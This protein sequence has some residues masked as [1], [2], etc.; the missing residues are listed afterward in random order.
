MSN[1]LEITTIQH[2][3]L[4][5]FINKCD[6]LLASGWVPL[7]PPQVHTKTE[8]GDHSDYRSTKFH[9]IYLQQWVLKESE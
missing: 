2:Y 4:D 1:I 7:F 6:K 5:Q 8:K 3:G 9:T